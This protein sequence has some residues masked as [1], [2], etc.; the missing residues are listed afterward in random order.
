[1]NQL[2][3]ADFR[4][5]AFEKAEQLPMPKPD[6]TKI[7]KWNFTDFPVHAVESAAFASLDELPEEVKAIDRY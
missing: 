3:F 7:T 4:V 1:M 2:G 5:D 6:K